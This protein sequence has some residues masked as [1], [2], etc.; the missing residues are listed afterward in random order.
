MNEYTC[1]ACRDTGIK[2]GGY[3]QC[4]KDLI[5]TQ[6]YG[7]LNIRSLKESFVVSDHTLFDTRHKYVDGTQLD[8]FKKIEI[9]AKR[10]AENFPRK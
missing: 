8:R 6:S 5:Y 4:L 9:Q 2:N 10:Y 1:P 3:C 7:A